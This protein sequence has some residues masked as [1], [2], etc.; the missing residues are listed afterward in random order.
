MKGTLRKLL[1]PLVF[2]KT[3][4]VDAGTESFEERYY[5]KKGGD[6]D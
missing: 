4:K 2:N 3:N 1:N 6:A 5:C